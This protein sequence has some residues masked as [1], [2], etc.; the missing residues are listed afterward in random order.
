ME[1]IP[2][3]SLII[4]VATISTF[5]LAVGAYIL[6]KLRE[7][8]GK[9]A[10][11]PQPAALPAELV[12]PAPLAAEQKATQTGMRRTLT[13]EHYP[14]REYGTGYQQQQERAQAGPEMRPTYVASTANGYTSDQRYTQSPSQ[15]TGESERHST[16]SRFLRYTKEGYVE[17]SHEDKKKED[18]LKWR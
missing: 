5:I 8:R 2:I 3:L 15:Y 18:N 11:A 16:R 6:Y 13:G 9:V 17:P 12:S 7:G 10:Q 1:L 4:L 14:S